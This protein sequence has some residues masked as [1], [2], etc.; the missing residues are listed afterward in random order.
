MDL[1]ASGLGDGGCRRLIG[2]LEDR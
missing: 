1:D 2:E